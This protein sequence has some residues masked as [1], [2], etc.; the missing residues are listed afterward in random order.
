MQKIYPKV[1]ENLVGEEKLTEYIKKYKGVEIQYF[2][3]DKD[4]L[5]NFVMKPAVDNIMKIHPEIEEITIHPPLDEY[6]IEQVLLSSENLLTELLNQAVELSEKYNIKINLIFHS[7]LTYIGHKYCTIG[8]IKEALK[9]LENT[10][11]KILLENIY[12]IEGKELCSLLEVCKEI[13]NEHLKLC[14]DMCHLYCRAHILKMSIEEF[15]SVFLNKELCEKYVYQIHF[16]DTKNN[17]GYLKK[18]THGRTYDSIDKM[19]YD[20]ELLKEYGMEGKNIVSEVSEE[21]YHER[22]DQIKTIKLL[23]EVYAQ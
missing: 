7:H 13:D 5:V 6:D 8:R 14:I 2:Q 23:E 15:L 10:N 21:N 9:I 19:K 22:E 1:C 12:M 4:E 3:K 20:L 18:E 17:D 16:A 11:V